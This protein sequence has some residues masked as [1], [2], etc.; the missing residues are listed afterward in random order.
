ARQWH[1]AE[2]C[3]RRGSVACAAGPAAGAAVWRCAGGLP[4]ARR[5][6]GSAAVA[7]AGPVAARQWHAA[8]P[9]VARLDV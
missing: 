7:A 1:A 3:G 5:Q 6:C 8:G 4:A 2:A 9:V